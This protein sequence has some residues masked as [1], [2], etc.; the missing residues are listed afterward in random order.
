MVSILKPV[1]QIKA[2]I[3]LVGHQNDFDQSNASQSTQD[4]SSCHYAVTLHGTM[5]CQLNIVRSDESQYLVYAQ[6]GNSTE[7]QIY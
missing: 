2:M 3:R 5:D 7:V 4:M 6:K 1:G